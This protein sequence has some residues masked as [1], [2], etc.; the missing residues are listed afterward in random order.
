MV[1]RLERR[2]GQQSGRRRD[3]GSEGSEGEQQQQQER[4]RKRHVSSVPQQRA[5][6]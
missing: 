2:G 1:V 6:S 5:E 3:Q 4:G